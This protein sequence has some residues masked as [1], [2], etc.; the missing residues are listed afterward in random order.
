M[1]KGVVSH[2]TGWHPIQEGQA[3]T[4]IDLKRTVIIYPHSTCMDHVVVGAYCLFDDEMNKLRNRIHLVVRY[5]SSPFRR[6]MVNSLPVNTIEVHNADGRNNGNLQRII[7]E[8]EKKDEWILIISPSGDITQ[9]NWRRGW[10]AVAEYF[11]VPV[12][13]ASPDYE[14]H[15][16]VIRS[17]RPIYVKN[18][19]YEEV[20]KEAKEIF[21]DIVPLNLDME[22]G[23]T[24]RQHVERSLIARNVVYALIAIILLLLLVCIIARWLYNRNLRATEKNDSQRSN[25]STSSRIRKVS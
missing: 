24:T 21:N 3:K 4:I 7:D 9:K 16:M 23:V 18:R 19:P 17:D 5:H 25:R 2:L 12:I 6:M 1:Y 20:E 15:E 13:V 8:L 22:V 14:K 11:D 10:H